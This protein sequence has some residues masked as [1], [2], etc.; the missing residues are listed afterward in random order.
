MADQIQGETRE[1]SIPSDTPAENQGDEM[2]QAQV[3][4]EQ[5]VNQNQG[6]DDQLSTNAGDA[7]TKTEE[8]QEKSDKAFAAMRLRIK[9]LEEQLESKDETPD[10]DLLNLSRGV[11]DQ[12]PQPQVNEV[13]DNQFSDDPATKEFLTRAQRAEYEAQLARNQAARA[14]A[15]LEDFEAWQ[16]F[17]QLNPKG[18]GADKSF[19]NDVS[20]AYTAARLKAI[21]AGKQPPR[22]VDVARQVDGRYEQIRQQALEQGQQEAQKLS[23]QKAAAQL[24]SRGTTVPVNTTDDRVQELRRRV[25]A[26]DINALA[27]L[28]K[29][30]DTFI[31]N[32]E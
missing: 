3:A 15:Q 5:E 24:E 14:A 28:N 12:L 13:D 4:P 29:L 17:P 20:N 18:K 8:E 11:S 10:L 23:E 25:R 16:E 26:G 30:E 19:I 6:R 9:E 22:L 1:E 2:S 7:P 32:W 31:S 27:E 21:N